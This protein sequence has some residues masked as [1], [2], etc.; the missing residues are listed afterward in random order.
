MRIAELF[1]DYVIVYENR[2]ETFAPFSFM[3][4]TEGS[5]YFNSSGMHINTN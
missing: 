5:V 4:F 3:D 2:D 1:E